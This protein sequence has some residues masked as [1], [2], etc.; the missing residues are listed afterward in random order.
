MTKS[1]KLIFGLSIGLLILSFPTCRIGEHA[2][3][4]ETVGLPAEFIS[5]HGFD[6]I[7]IRWVVPGIAMFF[8]SG[9]LALVAIVS[10]IAERKRA[11]AKPPVHER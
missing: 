5:A 9:F 8:L 3:A 6:W 7:F 1:T 2:A 10:W 4:N 11:N